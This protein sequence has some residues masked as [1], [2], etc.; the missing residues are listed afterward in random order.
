M[1]GQVPQLAQ[2]VGGPISLAGPQVLESSLFLGKG[3]QLEE[4]SFLSLPGFLPLAPEVLLGCMSQGA[5][6]RNARI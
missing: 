2:D 6:D 5:E 1:L 3:D 4:E